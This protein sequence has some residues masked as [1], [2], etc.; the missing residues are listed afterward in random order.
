MRETTRPERDAAVSVDSAVAVRPPRDP[1]PLL[2]GLTAAGWLLLVAFEFVPLGHLTH[3][4]HATAGLADG[5]LAGSLVLVL[6]AAGWLVMVAAMMLPTTVPM[7]RMF[8]VVSAHQGSPGP[9]RAAFFGAYLAVWLGFAAVALA[10]AVGMRLISGDA[11]PGLVLA[12]ALA[13]AGAFQFSPLKQRCLTACREP[14]AFLFAH[15]RRGVAGAWSV[16]LRH[17]WSCLG[18]CWALMLVMFATGV[19]DVAWM[20]GLT[21]V[22]VAEKTTRWGPRIVAPVGIA[23]L[24]AAV[25]LALGGLAT[26]GTAQ[27]VHV[28]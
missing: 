27:P 24:A 8:T 11:P 25:V 2:W 10:G 6:F 17:A 15:Y 4:A 3:A 12:G 19:A 22:M 9:A 20:L 18:C 7:A 5:V 28:H 26:F 14:A 16:G 21:A 13:L 1:G 23:L